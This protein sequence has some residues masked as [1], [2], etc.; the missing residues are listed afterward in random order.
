MPKEKVVDQLGGIFSDYE[1]EVEM[2]VMLL[3]SGVW[4]TKEEHRCHGARTRCLVEVSKPSNV[5]VIQVATG[6]LRA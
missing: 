6:R 1:C 4:E 2:Q 3:V 5:N